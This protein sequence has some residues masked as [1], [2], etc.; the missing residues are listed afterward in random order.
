MDDDFNENKHL[1]IRM[2][3]KIY[4]DSMKKYRKKLI[5]SLPEN[6]REDQF[7]AINRYFYCIDKKSK[8]IMSYIIDNKMNETKP[9]T[10]EESNETSKYRH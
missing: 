10:A 7:D 1:Y 2:L 5:S 9:M 4:A 8:E 3:D 6:I